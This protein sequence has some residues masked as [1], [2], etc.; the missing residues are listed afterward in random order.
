MLRMT[1]KRFL[2]F[3][4]VGGV[5]TGIDFGVFT[6]L[7]YFFALSIIPAHIAGFSLAVLNSYLMNK[8]WTFGDSA[9]QGRPGKEMILFFVTAIIGL[10]LSTAVIWGLDPYFHPLM[11]KAGAI[12]VTLGWNFTIS[13]FIVF[14]AHRL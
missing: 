5:N 7:I 6:A 10:C 11:A 4:V 8:F 13:H 1:H 12:F 3:C 14:R 2:K 9:G